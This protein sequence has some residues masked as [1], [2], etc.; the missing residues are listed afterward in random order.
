MANKLKKLLGNQSHW[1]IN[2]E[3]AREI[4]LNETLILQHLIDW[5]S[6][7]KKQTIFQ[8]YEQIQSELGLSEHAVKKVGIPALRKAGFI[9][10]ERKGVG[11]KIHYTIHEDVIFDFLSH[12]SSEVNTTPLEVCDGISPTSKVN[13]SYPIGENI[14]S[15]EVKTT[16][17]I[18][19][20]NLR[21]SNNIL[22]NNVDEEY[23]TKEYS[24]K[25]VEAGWDKD[26]IQN[27]I[28]DVLRNYN[29]HPEDKRFITALEYYKEAGEFNGVAEMMDW[30]DSVRDN[31]WKVLGRFRTI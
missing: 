23:M 2:K 13:T 20:N 8:T 14:M 5:S 10:T 17:P 6:Y 3:L 26:F 7:H 18:G 16:H 15:S 29:L 4:G 21:I 31:H 11:F 30:D 19:E 12:L 1:T 27:K 24:S 22:N 25:E 9:S 28:I